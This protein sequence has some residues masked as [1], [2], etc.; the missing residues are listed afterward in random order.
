MSEFEDARVLRVVGTHL[1]R[2]E[3]TTRVA[4]A[5]RWY[6]TGNPKERAELQW[7]VC[8]PV[9]AFFMTLIAVEIARTLPGSSAYPRLLAGIVVYAVVFNLAAAGRTWL[10]NDQVGDDARHVVG[11][12]CSRRCCSSRCASSRASV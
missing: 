5:Q 11:A 12:R 3:Q 1:R 7:R 10:E 2:R 4:Y 8:L 9:I 6:G